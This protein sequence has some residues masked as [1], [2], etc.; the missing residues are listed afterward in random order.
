MMRVLLF[1][2]NTAF[3]LPP[4]ERRKGVKA[5]H[6]LVHEMPEIILMIMMETGKVYKV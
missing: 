5:L 3:P 2:S 1:M 4:T 6:E